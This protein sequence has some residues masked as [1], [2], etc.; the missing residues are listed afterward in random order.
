MSFRLNDTV[1]EQIIQRVEYDVI[2]NIQSLTGPTGPIANYGILT[3]DGTLLDDI[4]PSQDNLYSLGSSSFQFNNIY[5]NTVYINNQPISVVDNVLQLPSGTLIGGVAI[6]TIKILGIK[7]DPSELPVSADIGDAYIIGN[8]L[9]VYSTS[10]VWVNIG[11]IVG[12][13]GQQGIT[14]PTGITGRTGATGYTGYT[15]PRGQ[16]GP[17]GY[18]GPRGL[19]GSPYQNTGIINL[20]DFADT[21]P[22][23]FI[24]SIPNLELWLD[25]DT[26]SGTYNTADPVDLWGSLVNGHIATSPNAGARPLYIQNAL[27]NKG[28]VSYVKGQQSVIPSYPVNR[29]G[30][31]VFLLYYLFLNIFHSTATF[32][33]I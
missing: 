11:S 27:N 13:Q 30:F 19:T 26:L 22:F 5:S 3:Q 32:C 7:N 21:G 16:T 28:I 20:G 6:G 10:L 18:T 29:S 2:R 23:N 1:L 31:S 15:G 12:P 17:T 8:N 33:I 14:G 24:S 25:A 4:I 9:W